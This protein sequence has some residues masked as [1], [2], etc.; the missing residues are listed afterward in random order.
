MSRE[1][2]PPAN[3][4]AEQAVLGAVLLEAGALDR[5]AGTIAAEDFYWEGHGVIFRA[6]LD[7]YGRREPVDL[8]TVTARLYD[9]GVLEQVGGLGF[10]AELAEHVGTTQNVEYYAGI[11]RGKARLRG[12]MAATRE[13]YRDCLEP[14]EEPQEVLDRA[15]RR[16]FELAQEHRTDGCTAAGLVAEAEL[17]LLEDLH[18]QGA[19][20]R[21]TGVGSGFADLDRL[22]AG[23]QATDLIVLAARPSMGKTALALNM[24]WHAA[25]A[26]TP[27]AVFSLEMSKEQLVRRLL[28]SLALVDANDLRR[29]F[30]SGEEWGR[31]NEAVADIRETPLVIDD[32]PAITVME[33]RAKCRRLAA[34]GR[35]GLVVVD[36]LQLMTGRRGAASREQEVSEISRA[37]KAM[38][39]ELNVPVIAL[40]QLNRELEKRTD[41]RPILADLRE[42]GAIEQDADVVVFIYRDEVYHPEGTQDKGMAEILVRKQRN[43]PTGEFKLFFRPEMTLFNNYAKND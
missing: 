29:A 21:L 7:L 28:V 35:L 15:E 42:S 14:G 30:L 20:R 25:R 1:Q 10:L 12:L 9:L 23:F 37:L 32:T 6:M 43:G 8:T 27:A 41:K 13:I 33:L 36:Y 5:V 18:R 4:E 22:T 11:V 19:A 26:G 3:Q 24:A 34:E 31:L 39:K 38:A 16:V 40:S 17:A 2:A